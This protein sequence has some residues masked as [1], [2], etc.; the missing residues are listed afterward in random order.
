MKDVTWRR[1]QD[2]AEDVLVVESA[3]GAHRGTRYLPRLP[4]G[5]K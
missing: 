4:L 3:E 2:L 1:T 5:D